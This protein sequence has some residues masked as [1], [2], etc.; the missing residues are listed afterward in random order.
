MFTR[1]Q[2]SRIRQEFWTT[3]GRYMSPIPS[4]EGM[5]TNWVN[6]HTRL[7]DVYFRMDAG[8]RSAAISISMEHT[9]PDI[10]E[11][12]FRQF[13]EFKSLLHAVL[14]EEWHWQLK[15]PLADGKI[16]SRIYKELPGVSVMN[17]DQWPELISFFKPRIIAL[18][19][20]WADA[21]YSFDGLR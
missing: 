17:K 8:Q 3:F 21:K 6:Y 2:A 14:E 16:V 1:E 18:D 20:F 13:V 10:Q 15:V 12:Y 19:S 9:D 11:L 7:K 4:A 5:K